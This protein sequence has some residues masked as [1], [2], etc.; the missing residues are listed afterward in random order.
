[1][2]SFELIAEQLNDSGLFEADVESVPLD[3]FEQGVE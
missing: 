2:P 1:V 3:E